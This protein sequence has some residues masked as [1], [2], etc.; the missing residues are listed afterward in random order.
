MKYE[1]AL[2]EI[3]KGAKIIYDAIPENEKSSGG[4]YA[5]ALEKA[6]NLWAMMN[7]QVFERPQKQTA[8]QGVGK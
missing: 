1:Q 8:T 3:N 6:G 2:E 5:I 7:Q 4:A